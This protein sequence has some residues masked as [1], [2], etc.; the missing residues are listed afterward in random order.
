MSL[1]ATP[2]QETVA[3]VRRPGTQSHLG[4]LSTC[5]LRHASDDRLVALARAGSE[6]AFAEIMRRYQRPLQFYCLHLVGAPR[7]EDAVQQAFLQA[8]VSLRDGARREI[9][10]RPWLYRIAR[11]C[12]IDLLRKQPFEHDELDPDFDGMPQTPGVFEQKEELARIVAAIQAL[13]E[14]QRRALTLRELEGRSYGEISAELGHTDSGVRQLIFRARTAL[15]NLGALLLPLDSIRWRLMGSTQTIAD[16]H[17]L[18]A[19][20]SVSSTGGGNVLQAAASAVAATVTLLA[21]APADRHDGQAPARA[22]SKIAAPLPGFAPL[23]TSATSTRAGTR[24]GRPSQRVLLR[25]GGAPTPDLTEEIAPVP[26]ALAVPAIPTA[27]V[28]P[29]ALDAPA[30]ALAAPSEAPPLTGLEATAG[31][32]VT[33]AAPVPTLDRA[34]GS[35]ATGDGRP[36]APAK[37]TAPAMKPASPVAKP[38]TVKPVTS[39]AKPL[40]KPVA[41]PKVTV[42]QSPQVKP[43]PKP[44]APKVS[45]PRVVPPKSAPKKLL[46]A[47]APAV[48]QKSSI[49]AA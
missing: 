36:T 43:V 10:L 21:S 22:P 35:T 27:A 31:T 40:A 16:P 15:R 26:P 28:A 44:A 20:A 8:F 42:P 23:A 24:H 41:P 33:A 30:P 11:N 17:Q 37:T 14:G 45:Q 3:P 34:T 4:A 12:A 38:V 25:S 9:A 6:R 46:P 18:A 47:K 2:G 7:A 48:P 29:P 13:P 39:P 5:S 19:A 32:D 49:P 1:T